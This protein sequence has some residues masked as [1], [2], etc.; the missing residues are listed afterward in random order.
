MTDATKIMLVTCDTL[1]GKSAR[2]VLTAYF[3]GVVSNKGLTNRL[4]VFIVEAVATAM[5]GP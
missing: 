1:K 4:L 3:V 2:Y 5:G